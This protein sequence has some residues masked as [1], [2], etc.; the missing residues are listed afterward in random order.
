[1]RDI[2]ASIHPRHAQAILDGTKTV[3]LRRKV[4]RMG[5]EIDRMFLYET[6]PTSALV[7]HVRVGVCRTM[8]PDELWGHLGARTGVTREEFDAYFDGRDEAHG[9]GLEWSCRYDHPHPITDLGLERPPQS[10]CYVPEPG[11]GVG[12]VGGG[13]GPVVGG[14]GV[15]S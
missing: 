4:W 9:I 15:A 3:E 6:A 12:G 14:E 13:G 2:V 11:A 5:A 10:W 1:M 7:G 8:P